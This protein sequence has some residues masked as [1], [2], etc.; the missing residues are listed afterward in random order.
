[1]NKKQIQ[2]LMNQNDKNVDGVCIDDEYRTL[3]LKGDITFYD[4]EYECLAYRY[5]L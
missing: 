2:K 1:M 3:Y 4:Y 5:K